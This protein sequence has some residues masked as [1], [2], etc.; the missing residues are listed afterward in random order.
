LN[1]F[2]PPR[3]VVEERLATVA[4]GFGSPA[5]T[6][7]TVGVDVTV[8]GAADEGWAAG[9]DDATPACTTLVTSYAAAEEPEAVGGTDDGAGALATDA[10]AKAQ[11]GTV[12]LTR[13]GPVT[14]SP[15]DADPTARPMFVATGA[16]SSMT[17]TT[18]AIATSPPVALMAAV[19][20]RRRRVRLG[21]TKALRPLQPRL[22]GHTAE[23]QLA[24]PPPPTASNLS[25]A[26]M[27]CV[28]GAFL[29]SG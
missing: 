19:H 18:D 15:L 27:E 11:L 4:L 10:W 17:A 16:S 7:D 21:L 1:P 28:R 2:V 23:D 9:A 20:L 26:G 22:R 13:A 25:S 8:A 5:G 12:G 14:A 24:R 3:C 6:D 29:Q